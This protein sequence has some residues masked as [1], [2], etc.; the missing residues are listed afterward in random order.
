[1]FHKVFRNSIFHKYLNRICQ[2]SGWCYLSSR[3]VIQ[4]RPL[5]HFW[6]DH[7]S[8]STAVLKYDPPTHFYKGTFVFFV[9]LFTSASTN[10]TLFYQIYNKNSDALNTKHC[11]TIRGNWK[12][13]FRACA[14]RR[15]KFCAW[16]KLAIGMFR[17][18]ILWI[19]QSIS[20][21]L[22]SALALVFSCRKVFNTHVQSTSATLSFQNDTGETISRSFF[23][24]FLYRLWHAA[25]S[26][27]SSC[28]RPCSED[29]SCAKPSAKRKW[30]I[31]QFA[32]APS[33]RLGFGCLS[34]SYW[35][36]GVSAAPCR[37]QIRV[38]EG[39]TARSCRINGFFLRTIWCCLHLLNRVFNMHLI[40]FLLC[41]LCRTV[42]IK[43]ELWKLSVLR[44]VFIPLLTHG[45]WSLVIAKRVLYQVRAAEMGIL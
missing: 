9:N 33:R 22:T 4:I 44:S 20:K 23:V 36:S 10:P 17:N 24:N 1:M 29:T 41:E 31:L 34:N 32:T 6:R 18:I 7:N 26:R 38:D 14:Q 8:S 43:R 21:L 35:L 45:H 30:L 19:Q 37:N 27:T 2:Y 5:D 40:G 15:F 25:E 39:V 12:G 16:V 13:W 3:A 42:V 28:W 11:P